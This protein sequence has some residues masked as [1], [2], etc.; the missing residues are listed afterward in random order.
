VKKYTNK[1]LF[2]LLII[3]VL[4]VLSVPL[5]TWLSKGSL[6]NIR[7]DQSSQQVSAGYLN[8]KGFNAIDVQGV[9][10]V[11]VI[12]G[13]FAIELGNKQDGQYID[14][15]NQTLKLDNSLSSQSQGEAKII[16]HLP[17]LTR[18][19]IS[20]ASKVSATNFKQQIPTLL[21]LDLSGATK[22]I[23]DNSSYKKIHITMSG[24]SNISFK[25]SE[26][27]QVM[28]DASGVSKLELN[29]FTN[30]KL[31]GSVSG[32]ANISYSG[33]LIQ[34]TIESSGVVDIHQKN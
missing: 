22:L 33:T 24:A 28:L 26:L 21:N 20:G 11:Q 12:P 25:N 18:L 19:S 30:G 32:A 4:A 15:S 1:T 31:S 3:I 34:N 7:S 9:W 2:V 14:L 5:L 29:T 13:D 27:E 17:D 23:V 8:Y 16:I 10:Q 6:F